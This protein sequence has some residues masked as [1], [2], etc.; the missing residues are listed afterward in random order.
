MLAVALW[1]CFAA[2]LMWAS[3][4]HVK[5]DVKVPAVSRTLMCEADMKE[6]LDVP[7]AATFLIQGQEPVDPVEGNPNHVEPEHD[8]SMNP[9]QG[10]DMVKCNCMKYQTCENGDHSNEP[11]QCKSYC[12]RHHCACP[13]PCE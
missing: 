13:K 11:T 10:S 7:S 12:Y 5:A 3:E 4:K 8:C 1:L 2:V 6:W 9:K